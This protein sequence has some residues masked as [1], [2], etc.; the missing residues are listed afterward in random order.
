MAA[1][2]TDLPDTPRSRRPPATTPEARENQLISVAMDL[3]ERQITD[4]TASA[5]VI[6]HFLKLGSSREKLEQARLDQ[7]VSLLEAKREAM[8]SAARVEELYGAAIDAMR[9]YAGNAQPNED[10]DLDD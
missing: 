4:G 5:Q 8:A 7:E 1:K 3:A 2:R 10:E 9:A 6:S